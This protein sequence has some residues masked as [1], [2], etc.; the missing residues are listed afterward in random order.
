MGR[1]DISTKEGL[2]KLKKRVDY[3]CAK[4][5]LWLDPDDTLQSVCVKFIERPDCK[6]TVEQLIID[7]LREEYGRKGLPIYEGKQRMKKALNYEDYFK[8]KNSEDSNYSDI[9]CRIDLEKLLSV[10]DD[11]KAL[12][13]LELIY[14]RGWQQNEVAAFLGVSA[15]L[16][17]FKEKWAFQDIREEFSI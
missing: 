10:V 11:E 4:K 5:F 8:N 16:I 6:A 13:V 14:V 2:A 1:I 7:I 15:T 3:L 9:D 12:Q 17:Y